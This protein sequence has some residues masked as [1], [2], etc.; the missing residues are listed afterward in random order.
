M[1]ILGHDTTANTTAFVLK[2]LARH[3][4]VQDKLRCET[5]EWLRERGKRGQSKEPSYQDL[6]DMK[7][8][9]AVHIPFPTQ[10]SWSNIWM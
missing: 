2:M 10:P 5:T 9:D 1:F 3:P 8:L 7:Y 4:E 6:H